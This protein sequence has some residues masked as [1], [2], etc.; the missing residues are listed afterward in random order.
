MIEFR[1]WQIFPI[2]G[3]DYILH[4]RSQ[5]AKLARFMC[6]NYSFYL[7][8][9][10]EFRHWIRTRVLTTHTRQDALSGLVNQ[11]CYKISS[12]LSKDTMIQFV[13][14]RAKPDKLYSRSG[15]EK[16][17]KKISLTFYSG[18]LTLQYSNIQILH[19][20][21]VSILRCQYSQ[22]NYRLRLISNCA[23][24]QLYLSITRN[25]HEIVF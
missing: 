13:V 14:L 21:L 24:F 18:S 2:F 6:Q 7:R 12:N 23:Q 3:A 11:L 5:S 17:K 22:F 1:G 10:S 19:Q 16:K 4:K 9:L 20:W 25:S 15:G 8:Q